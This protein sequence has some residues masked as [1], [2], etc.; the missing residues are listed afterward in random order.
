MNI[1]LKYLRE[2]HSLKQCE[3]SRKSGI[4]HAHLSGLESGKCTVNLKILKI[5]SEVFEIPVSQILML[6]ECLHNN[7]LH[8]KKIQDFVC[9]KVKQ[10]MFW[11]VN[12]VAL[13]YE[14]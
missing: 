14:E 10:I 7:D 6:D 1:T 2:F 8:N 11:I 5:Y 4:S 12:Q 9:I 13:D 3:L